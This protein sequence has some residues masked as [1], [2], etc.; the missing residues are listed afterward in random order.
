MLS[1][2]TRLEA[3]YSD[4]IEDEDASFPQ[5][6]TAE[7]SPSLA[8]HKERTLFNVYNKYHNFRDKPHEDVLN[9]LLSWSS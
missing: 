9:M 7:S 1:I 4:D 5:A 2:L 3:P 8:N 6:A